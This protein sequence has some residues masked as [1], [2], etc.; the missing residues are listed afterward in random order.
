MIVSC[1]AITMVIVSVNVNVFQSTPSMLVCSKPSSS[2]CP[3]QIPPF[4]YCY[5]PA[6]VIHGLTH[7]SLRKAALPAKGAIFSFVRDVVQS[8]PCGCRS[9]HQMV[10]AR[11]DAQGYAC[12]RLCRSCKLQFSD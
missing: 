11:Q 9:V 6:V 8:K 12:T 3:K 7:E 5:L 1:V 4:L 2:R 10:T